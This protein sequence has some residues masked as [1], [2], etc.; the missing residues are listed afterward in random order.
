MCYPYITKWHSAPLVQLKMRDPVV[1]V[2]MGYPGSITLASPQTS[3]SGSKILYTLAENH[4]TA[5]SYPACPSNGHVYSSSKHLSISQ[6]ATVR[7]VV[8]SPNSYASEVVSR[9]ARVVAPAPRVEIVSNALPFTVVLG[10]ESSSSS[11]HAIRYSVDGSTPTCT[12]QSLLYSAT[13]PPEVT[14]PCIVKS[15]S[16]GTHLIS[17][18]VTSLKIAQVSKPTM[19]TESAGDSAIAVS[20]SSVTAGA[21]IRYSTSGTPNCFGTNMGTILAAGTSFKLEQS[22]SVQAVACHSGMLPSPVLAQSVSIEGT[23]SP[24]TGGAPSPPPPP[25]PQKVHKVKV[26]MSLKGYTVDSFDDTA[27]AA[28]SQG[29]AVH[30]GVNSSRIV[31]TNITSGRRSAAVNVDF[32]IVAQGNAGSSAAAEATALTATIAAAKSDPSALITALKSSGLTETKD[33]AV[34]AVTTE[35]IEVSPST[36]ASPTAAQLPAASSGSADIIIFLAIGGGSVAAIMLVT[37]FALAWKYSASPRPPKS[38][39]TEEIVK[40]SKLENKV[41]IEELHAQARP[42][43][44]QDPAT[45]AADAAL[46]AE[47]GVPDALRRTKALA[48]LR[49]KCEEELE[50]CAQELVEMLLSDDS[51]AAIS[52]AR[53]LACLSRDALDHHVMPLLSDRDSRMRKMGME[54][55]RYSSPSQLS[56]RSEEILNGLDD[57]DALVRVT[58]LDAYANLPEQ[59]FK[60][61]MDVVV[62]RLDD[63]EQAVQQAA[64]RVLDEAPPSVLTDSDRTAIYNRQEASPQRAQRAIEQMLTSG[65]PPTMGEDL[66]EWQN[67]PENRHRT[68][69]MV[70]K[71]ITHQA[72]PDTTRGNAADRLRAGIRAKTEAR[73]KANADLQ[74]A[75]NKC[76]LFN[77]K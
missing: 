8:C 47:L 17:S 58:A 27:Q 4:L 22:A 42:E 39:S 77:T 71:G 29:I 43:V 14:K 15:V 16:C 5:P 57:D 61:G 6:H 7:A 64:R 2:G 66:G 68:E 70:E 23:P 73:K 67:S 20:I 63:H 76:G 53:V 62:A 65:G 60:E 44:R 11:R 55:L 35:V 40:E 28:F 9:V 45:R 72:T 46:V 48:T 49:S 52:A 37:L 12:Q 32:H 51:E 33:L 26:S 24:S 56:C 75:M 1:S 3:A 25:P 50:G 10:A 30:I 59:Q 19:T 54:V 69:S 36:P 41:G 21:I 34:T 18:S 74:S 13:Q 38:P 31:I